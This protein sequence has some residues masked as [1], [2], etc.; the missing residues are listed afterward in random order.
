MNGPRRII[1]RVRVRCNATDDDEAAKYAD[2]VP[3]R[4]HFGG[5]IFGNLA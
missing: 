5:K 4:V 2:D 1:C 3:E